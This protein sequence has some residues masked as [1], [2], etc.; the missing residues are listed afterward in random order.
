MVPSAMRGVIAKVRRSICVCRTHPQ[1]E[2]G[3]TQGQS[4]GAAHAEFVICDHTI[5]EDFRDLKQA[6]KLE[7]VRVKAAEHL[8]VL[9]MALAIV[10]YLLAVLGVRAEKLGYATQFATPKKGTR[11]LS[12]CHLA[13]DMLKQ[14]PK[15]L[16]L[17]FHAQ[18]GVFQLRWA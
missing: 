11:T 4:P 13:L 3:P 9:L 5:E 14:S 18:A 12:W 17:L 7:A 1:R 8:D 16:D 15:H 2:P 6:F 10:I